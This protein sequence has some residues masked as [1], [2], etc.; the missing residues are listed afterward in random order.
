MTRV[1][2]VWWRHWLP[3]VAR[4]IWR[5]LVLRLRH[6]MI[7]HLQSCHFHYFSFIRRK[8]NW[9]PWRRRHLLTEMYITLWWLRFC[10]LRTEISYI[11]DGAFSMQC[12]K[13]DAINLHIHATFHYEL[14]DRFQHLQSFSLYHF[15]SNVGGAMPMD[16]YNFVPKNHNIQLPIYR[17]VPT[18][19]RKLCG[20]LTWIAQLIENMQSI[21]LS[22]VYSYV[23]YVYVHISLF[24]R[25]PPPGEL[26]SLNVQTIPPRTPTKCQP[27]TC[28]TDGDKTE[29]H[30][31]QTVL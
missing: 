6:S 31:K 3:L 2:T 28:E 16:G 13:L 24:V 20:R 9:G 7:S 4:N 5:S 8:D 23:I 14:S 25:S 12:S 15:Q 21:D 19:W 11:P 26:I 29:E 22:L 1:L 27:Q 18:V 30:T 17:S 10:V